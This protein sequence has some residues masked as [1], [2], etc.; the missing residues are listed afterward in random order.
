[1]YWKLVK[2]YFWTETCL[3]RHSY[4]SHKRSITK[5]QITMYYGMQLSAPKVTWNYSKTGRTTTATALCSGITSDRTVLCVV[6]VKIKIY[7]AFSE[8]SCTELLSENN[9]KICRIWK[10]SRNPKSLYV[11]IY[12]VLNWTLVRWNWQ[13]V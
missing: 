9:L 13:H 4:I 11:H 7:S 8:V 1:M 12:G 5:Q 6:L 3:L 2:V 10:I